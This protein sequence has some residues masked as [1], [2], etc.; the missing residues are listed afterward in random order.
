[1]FIIRGFFFAY[2]TY[3]NMCFRTLPIW[4][5]TRDSLN[6]FFLIIYYFFNIFIQRD[7]HMHHNS[8]RN[9]YNFEV[10]F[11]LYVL[12][13]IWMMVL[14]SFQCI[15]GNWYGFEKGLHD[16]NCLSQLFWL[17]MSRINFTTV[18]FIILLSSSKTLHE[19]ELVMSMATLV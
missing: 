1:M 18:Q 6:L 9:L 8:L 7:T 5:I 19:L 3:S 14:R 11:D 17:N 15:A 13:C 4:F 10:V 16:N 2:I 12:C